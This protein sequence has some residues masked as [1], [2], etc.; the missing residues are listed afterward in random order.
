MKNVL[1]AII[2]L[3]LAVPA[4]AGGSFYTSEPVSGSTVG[5]TANEVE[6]TDNG[7]GSVTLGLTDG[8]ILNAPTVQGFGNAVV[9]SDSAGLLAQ[10]PVNFIWN[11]V[12]KTLSIG[13][14]NILGNLVVH[15][16]IGLE[17]EMHAEELTIALAAGVWANVAGMSS[18][19]VSDSGMIQNA[20]DGS[21]TVV[22]G[23]I[24]KLVGSASLE[25]NDGPSEEYHLVPAINGADQNKC[26]EHR[27][28]TVQASL[29]S[30]SISCLLDLSDG[31]VIT[32]LANSV[33]GDDIT[34][35][36]INWMLFK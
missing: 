28:I 29:A 23:H 19:V 21:V 4:F 7:D 27:S 5:G 15:G 10:D 14:I 22:T 2:I 20:T 18:G 3:L 13:N 6:V 26:E 34:L 17:A 9:F 16:D 11:D 36:H 33:G 8:V 25:D 30:V 32:M 35:E 1:I 31:D 12:T 24:Y